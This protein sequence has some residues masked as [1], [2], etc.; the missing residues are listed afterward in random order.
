MQAAAERKLLEVFGTGTGVPTPFLA[1]SICDL[2]R[3]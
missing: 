1:H 2:Q 3:A